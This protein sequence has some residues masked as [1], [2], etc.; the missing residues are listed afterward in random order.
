MFFS[1]NKEKFSDQRFTFLSGIDIRID[2]LCVA[3]LIAKSSLDIE[4]CHW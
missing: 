2:E 4:L 1:I 3:V